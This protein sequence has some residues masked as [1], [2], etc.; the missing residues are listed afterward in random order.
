MRGPP[1]VSSISGTPI[2]AADPRLASAP[3]ISSRRFPGV[4]A[5]GVT[6]AVSGS[7]VSCAVLETMWAA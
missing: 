6:Q 4:D 7:T 1:A 2:A 3:V 5:Q